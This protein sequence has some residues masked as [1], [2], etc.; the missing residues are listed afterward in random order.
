M[1]YSIYQMEIYPGNPNKNRQKVKEWMQHEMETNNPDI[2]VLPEMWTTSY[3]LDELENIADSN[4]EPSK[5]FLQELAKGLQVNIIGGS[6]ANKVNGVIYNTSYVFNRSGDLVYTYNK[7]HL[8]PMLNEPKY[9]TGGQHA[10]EV[11]EL[12]DIKMGLVICYDLR[13][14]EITRTLAIE[15]AEVLHIVAEWPIE[16]INHWKNL[17]IARAIENQM[18]VVSSNNVGEYDSVR[19]GGN[20][21]VIDPGGDIVQCGSNDKEETLFVTLDLEKVKNVRENIPIFKSRVPHLYK[22]L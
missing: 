16:R 8:V 9:L 20:S 10:P 1:K 15:G 13:F 14:P 3:T 17:Q 21:M 4:G 18:Y 5:S 19:Y 11:F 7:I 22:S 6:I 12:D 2:V